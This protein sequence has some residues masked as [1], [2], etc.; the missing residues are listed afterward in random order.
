[1]SL[2]VIAINKGVWNV[3]G[4]F[5]LKI[6]SNTLSCQIATSLHSTND[7]ANS[8]SIECTTIDDLLDELK[9]NRLDMVK[10]DIEGAEIEA[11]QGSKKTL[12]NYCPHVAIASYHKRDNEPTYHKVEEILYSQG[13]CANTFFPPHLTTCGKKAPSRVS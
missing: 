13:Y 9:L 8:L 10:M 7:S 6:F 1:M 11:L 5:S 4:R 2:A 12:S 3:T